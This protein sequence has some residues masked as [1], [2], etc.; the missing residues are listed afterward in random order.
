MERPNKGLELASV[1]AGMSRVAGGAAASMKAFRDAL[2]GPD[3]GISKGNRIG[4]GRRS[5]LTMH[6]KMRA[7]AMRDT[8]GAETMRAVVA[9]RASNWIR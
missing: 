8:R 1:F 9:L 7:N 5:I 3:T 2:L 4:P 6:A